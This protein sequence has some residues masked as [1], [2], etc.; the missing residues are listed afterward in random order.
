[1][2]AAA[3]RRLV[4]RGDSMA[5]RR[6]RT[7]AAARRSPSLARAVRG[8][9]SVVATA[10]EIGRLPPA[11]HRPWPPPAGPWVMKQTWTN[12]LF[13]HWPL[14][15]RV[16]RPLVPAG[17]QLETFESQAWVGITPF[18]LTGLRPRSMPA[19]PGVSEF[20]EINVRTYVT[21]G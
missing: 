17:L 3:A 2:P 5:G 18:V 8:L 20:P 7:N 19:V 12:L 4:P 1:M 21:A 13:A 6:A 15:P 14:P 11:D 16:L 10:A 9:A